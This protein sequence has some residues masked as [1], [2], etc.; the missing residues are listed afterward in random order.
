M[1]NQYRHLLSKTAPARQE[2]IACDM[3]YL[4]GPIVNIS[5]KYFGPDLRLSQELLNISF[6]II[7]NIPKLISINFFDWSLK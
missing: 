3:L 1:G 7:V 4:L 5:G 6:R 2:R